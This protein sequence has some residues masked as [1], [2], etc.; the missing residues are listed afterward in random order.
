MGP[1][2]PV[3]QPPRSAAPKQ[4]GDPK[5]KRLL[6]GIGA[7]VVAL[8][9]IIGGV[10]FYNDYQTKQEQARAAEAARVAEE[11]RRNEQKKQAQAASGAVQGYLQ[12]LAD[13]DADKAL[14][15]AKDKPTENIQLLTRDVLLEANK[16]A[17]I[18]VGQLEPAAV[19]E[20]SQGVWATGKVPAKFALGDKEQTVEFPVTRVGDDWKLDRLSAKIDLG[21]NGPERLVNGVRVA[22]GSYEMFPGSYS[23]TSANPLIRFDGTEF[24]F[25]D[26]ADPKVSWDEDAVLTDEGKKQSTEALRGAINACLQKKELAPADCQFMRFREANGIKVNPSTIRYTLKNDPYSNLN[27][28]FS[29]GT[30]SA[31]TAVSLTIELNA[32]AS[33]NGN[34]GTLQPVTGSGV[35]SVTAKLADG[36]PTIV[37]N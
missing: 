30:M 8:I 34:T 15:Y 1:Q 17:A 19:T 31:S 13:A 21:L 9:L 3:Q 29:S 27:W 36:R 26:P 16:R 25:A 22:P 28:R 14:G 12:A 33:Q 18:K 24:S 4:P 6:I 35:V 32:T 23:V 20:N 11:N 2:Q 37:F 7:A 10:V 5:R